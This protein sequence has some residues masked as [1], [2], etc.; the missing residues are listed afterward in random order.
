MLRSPVATVVRPDRLAS[1]PAAALELVSVAK[2]G[3]W[4]YNVWV[5]RVIANSGE[6]EQLGELPPKAVK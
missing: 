4:L 2:A 6:L 5:Y 3:S 1:E